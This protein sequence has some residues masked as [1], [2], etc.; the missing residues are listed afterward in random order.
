MNLPCFMLAG[1]LV[2]LARPGSAMT[3]QWRVFTRADGLRENACV[4]V[5]LG[6]SGNVLVRHARA[7]EVTVFDGYDFTT[8]AAP[9]T[10]RGRVYESPGGQLWTVARDG[11]LEFRDGEWVPYPVPQIAAHF[12]AGLTNEIRL[13]PPRQGRVLIALPRETLHLDASDPENPRLEPAAQ[14]APDSAT[15]PPP[16]LPEP[17]SVRHV[18]DTQTGPDGTI[19]FATSDGLF[20][21]APELWEAAPPRVPPDAP[22]PRHRPVP[23]DAG[24]PPGGWRVA[25]TANNGEEWLGGTHGVARR[26]PDS[27]QFFLSTNRLGPEEVFAFAEAP[28][29]RLWCAT[30]GKVWQFDGRDWLSVRGGFNPIHALHAAR[31]G[32]LWVATANGLYRLVHGAWVAHGPEDGLP[33]ADTRQIYETATGRLVVRTAAGWS[34]FRP[35]A[36]PDPPRTYLVAPP[37]GETRFPEGALV[38]LVFRGR[39]RW[40]QTA[41]ERLLFSY[42]LDERDWSPFQELNEVTFADLPLGKHYFQVRALDRAGNVSPQPAR[43]EFVL[44]V[45]WYRE[46][47]LV[48]VLAAALGVTLFFAA[49]AVNRHRRLRLSYAEV[50]RQVAE[51]TRELELANRELLHSQKMTALGTLAAG[52]AHDFNNLLSIIKGSAQLIEENLANPEKIRTR[53]DRIKTAVHQGAGI[54]E[55]MLGF[56]RDSDQPSGPYDLN[57]VVDDTIKLLGDRF[58]REVPVCFERAATLPEVC[59]PRD[60]VQQILLNFI[61]NA[62]EATERRPA[63]RAKG[64]DSPKDSLLESLN[65]KI[66]GAPASSP[67]W[68]D[69]PSK[70][71]GNAGAPVHGERLPAASAAHAGVRRPGEGEGHG[72]QKPQYTGSAGDGPAA[73]PP[74]PRQITVTTRAADTLPAE[75]FL[76]P[77]RAPRFVCV[78]VRD[79]GDGIPPEILPRIFEPFFTTKAL[80]ARRGTGLGLTMVYELARK[81][82]AGLAVETALG[83]GSTFT[84]ILPVGA[85]D[86]E[87]PRS[88]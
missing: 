56:S 6:A 62:A 8:V 40:K 75:L 7:G 54:V 20:R 79:N 57:A 2:L 27:V 52:I 68:G 22:P 45:P 58:L 72:K 66:E 51:R 5:T 25:F 18:Y 55:A 33:S 37:A 77:D 85:P 29:G 30:P 88:A 24:P 61:F 67:A 35:E 14:T 10:N 12:R 17:F 42:R 13:Q 19:W 82:G 80:S 48:L 1:A 16:L 59:V 28:D 31:D 87:P 3:N 65:R 83:Q 44:A 43:L 84:L 63:A 36:D 26:R 11:L 71:S 50:E 21:H 47:R 64:E 73:A 49:L 38:T 60:F 74:L 86:R 32:T 46:T 78:A 81:M 9:G 41:P 23:P 53:V 69:R 76:A 39:D 15:G 70:A 34:V 4:S